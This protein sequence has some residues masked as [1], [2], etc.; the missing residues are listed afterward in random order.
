MNKGI[1]KKY[2][3]RY[4]SYHIGGGLRWEYIITSHLVTRHTMF[5]MFPMVDINIRLALGVY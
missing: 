5:P 3:D 1:F 2:K 4:D